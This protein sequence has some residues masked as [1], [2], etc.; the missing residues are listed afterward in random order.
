[1]LHYIYSDI[2][3]DIRNHCISI[4]LLPPLLGLMRC[5]EDIDILLLAIQCLSTVTHGCDAVRL[6]LANFDTIELLL[7]ILSSSCSLKVKNNI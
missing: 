5:Y 7:S 6:A 2:S 4:G 1:M 3:E